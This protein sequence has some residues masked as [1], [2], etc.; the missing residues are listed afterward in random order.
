MFINTHYLLWEDGP[1]AL[2][3]PSLPPIAPPS[4][5][6]PLHADYIKRKPSRA[7]TY[8][9]STHQ[10]SLTQLSYLCQQSLNIVHTRKYN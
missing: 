8:F 1:T 10:H 4:L 5:T 7:D 3:H 9:S 2:P 6:L